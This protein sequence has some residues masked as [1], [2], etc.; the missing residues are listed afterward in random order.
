M[1]IE[2]PAEA[3]PEGAALAVL[4]AKDLVLSQAAQS[5]DDAA[6]GALRRA[7]QAAR[8]NGEQGKLVEM[9]A[10]AS[11]EA[12]RVILA[13]TGPQGR[14][15][16]LGFERIGAALAAKLSRSG[17]KRLVVDLRGASDLGVPV[18]QAAARIGM[19]LLQ[20]GYAFDHYR[21]KMPETQKVSLEQVQIIGAGDRAKDAFADLRESARG[22]AFAKDLVSEPANIVYPES[23]VERV[24]RLELS[25]L[26]IDVL[27]EEQMR[28][29]GMNALLGVSQGSEREARLLIME[30][31]GTGGSADVETVFVGKGVTFDSGGISI[32]PGAGMEDMKWDMGGA[33]AVTGAMVALAAR[34]A[35][36]RVV[37]ICG[38]V[39]NMPDGRAQRPG[40][41]VTSM[42]GQTVEVIN[43][44]A[45]GRLVLCDAMWWAQET[46]KP[47]T[48]IDL[49]TLT[50]AMIIGLGHH[51]AGV[52]SNDD[53]LAQ[54]LVDAG[55][56]T[57]DK[58]WRMPV[59]E[60]YDKQINSQIAD[61]KNVGGR[62]AGSITA[63]QF[64]QRFVKDGVK[65]AHLDI[66]GMVW[67]SKPGT[68]HDKGATG[69]GVRLLD[70]YVRSALEK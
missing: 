39:E 15:D 26:N 6:G 50:G 32:K 66:A 40:D 65:W 33:A 60:E 12:D 9:L 11:T 10:G 52:F 37:G 19:G 48:V 16:A 20:R 45:E 24:K 25:G 61:M 18:E 34:K 51:H 49:A 27:N 29:A 3:S 23:F 14:G 41:V 67:A 68:M 62:D 47:K 8:F 31:D 53:K 63:A 56:A 4:T 57:G 30:W 44:D 35:K 43:T 69:Y 54:A 55:A 42:S 59:G 28:E 1:Q 5:L 17:T 21:T 46:Y 13:G 36:A 38:L 70:E 58:L 22:V 7:A 2:F 64:L